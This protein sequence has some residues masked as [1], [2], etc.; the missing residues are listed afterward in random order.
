MGER[1]IPV[2]RLAVL[3]EGIAEDS[4]D[5]PFALEVPV[6]TLRWPE[7]EGER[8]EPPTLM[9]YLQLQDAV[10]MFFVTAVVRPF[11]SSID[12]YRS[13]AA[14]VTFDGLTNRIIPF[15]MGLELTGLT[16]PRPG[17]Y[18][19]FVYANHASLHDPEGRMPIPFPPV[20]ITVLPAD[21][22]EGGV[23]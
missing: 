4:D 18:E 6:H 3:C 23:L 20:R 22:T 14:E 17:L 12:I 5:R 21:D 1:I 16:F 19:L 8:Y 15:E 10:G 7:W 13:K 9:L 11:G 2:L